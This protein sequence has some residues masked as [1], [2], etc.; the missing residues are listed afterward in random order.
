MGI[1]IKNMF[2]A[3]I[4]SCLSLVA[5]SGEVVVLN[6]ENFGQLVNDGE[7][8]LAQNGNGWFVKFYAPW[9][10]HCKKLAPVWDELAADHGEN[11]NVAKIDCTDES[12]RPICSQYGNK[13]F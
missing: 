7:K 5:M 2:K 3:I 13:G 4:A 6:H 12:N 9:C 1:V 8:N 11:V 10:G